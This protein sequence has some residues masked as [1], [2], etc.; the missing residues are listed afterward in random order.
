MLSNYLV[1]V[2]FVNQKSRRILMNPDS[3]LNES[4]VFLSS[5]KYLKTIFLLQRHSFGFRKISEYT[6]H[7]ILSQKFVSD[8]PSRRGVGELDPLVQ[9]DHLLIYVEYLLQNRLEPSKRLYNHKCTFSLEMKLKK[10][11]PEG[12][13]RFMRGKGIFTDNMVMQKVIEKPGSTV[14]EIAE[15]LSWTSGRVDGSVNRLLKE[16]KIRVQHCIRRGM[17]VKKVYTMH[18]Y[19]APDVIEIPKE[20]IAEGLWKD[21][22]YVYSLSRSS[23]AISAT[24]F[25]EWEKKAFWKGTAP[26]EKDEEKLT[27]KIPEL[28]SDFYRLINSETSISTT[29]EFALVT[30]ESTIVPIELPPTFPARPVYKRTT[31]IFRVDKIERAISVPTGPEPEFYGEYVED[32]ER[33]VPATIDYGAHGRIRTLSPFKKKTATSSTSQRVETPTEPV[34]E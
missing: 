17:I 21:K 33:S 31:Y 26:I 15:S 34:V 8:H 19:R 9:R 1:R 4:A 32:E 6:N 12:A 13:P 10:D 24:K 3:N 11:L 25:E 27:V 20:I 30:V 2:Q 18:E 29:D 7:H 23:I 5:E 14:H 16:G 28:L 22:A